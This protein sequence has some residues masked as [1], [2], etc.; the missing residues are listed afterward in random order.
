[1]SD[2][3]YDLVVLGTGSGGEV[4]A[5]EV[6]R[7]GGTVAA[8]DMARIGGECPYVACVPSKAMLLA[9]REHVLVGG[10]DATAFA[11]AVRRRD[12]AARGR[13]DSG[14]A[15]QLQDDGVQ[16]VR[17]RGRIEGR[18]QGR[19][20]ADLVVVVGE[21]RLRASAV[22]VGTGSEAVTPPI[23][24]LDDVPTWTSEQALSSLERPARLAILGGGPVGC[25]LA[26]VYASFGTAVVLVEAA[27]RLL[28]NEPAFVGERLASALRELGV[29]V[30]L[31]VKVTG[32]TRHG[33]RVRL[34][35]D[36]DTDVLADRVLV[37]T[38]RRPR[39]ADLGL[40]SVGVHRADAGA[41][42]VDGRCRVLAPDASPV[43]GLFA[44]GDVT[45]VAPFTHT[46]AYQGRIVAAHLLGTGRDADYSGV[47]RAVYTH[48]AVF[49]VGEPAE[50]AR[51]R[52]VQAL[53]EGIELADTARGF[54][55]GAIGGRLELVADAATGTLLGASAIG[56]DADSWMGEL[57][58]AVRA[59]LDVRL[60]ADQVRA[61]PAW[62]EAIEPVAARLAAR[63]NALGQPGPDPASGSA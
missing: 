60:L 61:F 36:G 54:L 39:S 6:A 30:R 31:G 43:P 51:A 29:D 14:A 11:R 48:P 49:G 20:D 25:E 44:V 35:I 56:P 19:A 27:P 23:D 4:V 47:P 57:A 58:L 12:A 26:Q 28:A 40:E 5:A 59:H 22:V 3:T 2:A 63:V 53:V 62:S 8:V 10:A 9:A 38:G 13:D 55:A 32:A 1:M 50:A 7:A 52:G 18:A 45:G 46:A 41:L 24:G 17:G 21:R 33:S 42:A 34:R 15:R 37:A 16:V